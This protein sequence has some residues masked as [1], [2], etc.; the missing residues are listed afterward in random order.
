M[1]PWS[2]WMVHFIYT[3]VSRDPH[4]AGQTY[5]DVRK[6]CSD[7]TIHHSPYMRDG[8]LVM[9]LDAELLSYEGFGA[10]PTE[11]IF[12]SDCFLCFVVDMGKVDLHWIDGVTAIFLEAGDSPWSLNVDGILTQ[13]LDED[14]LDQTLMQQ[15]RKRVSRINE[16]WTA[17]PGPRPS[18]TPPFCCRIPERNLIHL[19]VLLRTCPC[20]FT[21]NAPHTFAGSWA[22]I[23]LF[24][25][26][27]RNKSSERG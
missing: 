21:R 26:I 18:D 14:P 22:M 16:T 8:I 7:Y 5:L 24:K 9:N 13:V 12:C 25:P 17:R 15:S 6:V 3:R 20:K 19:Q 11:E 23:C 2:E 10:F 1:E 4:P 27:F